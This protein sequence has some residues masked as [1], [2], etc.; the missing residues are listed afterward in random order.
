MK[1]DGSEI[2]FYNTQDG[3]VEL[4]IKLDHQ[5]QTIWLTQNQMAELFAVSVK[6]VN[7]HLKNIFEESELSEEGTIRNFRTV[8]QEGSREVER[9]ISHYNLKAILAVGYRVRSNRGTQ[10][11]KWATEQLNEYLVKGFVMNDKRLKNP[12][13]WDYFDELLERIKD[14][15]ASEKRF[16]QKI[17]DLVKETSVDY[18]KTQSQTKEFF[19]NL[20]N[21]FLFAQAGKTAAELIIERADG[22]KPN[23]G[24]T[25][26]DGAVVRKRDI[27]VAKNYLNE[28][29]V[30]N[31]NRL[32]NMF[33]D[34]AEDRASR[35]EEIT[36]AQWI[37][38]TEK[39][40]SFNEREVLGDSGSKSRQQM[41]EH[42]HNE[43]ITFEKNRLEALREQAEEEHI[44]ELEITLRKIKK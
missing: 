17:R 37:V 3:K 22:H 11:R 12:G 7:E 19:S 15:R 31:L 26:F 20:Q 32:V 44:K 14:I 10:F 28:D 33:L 42:T 27:E 43:Y 6:T 38:Q 18:D 16:Y 5:E 35:R 34:F 24:L 41:L 4:E 8:R 2:I 25:T 30:K 13:G 21:K 40:L 1:N 29:E 39:F 9:E 23:M 36:L